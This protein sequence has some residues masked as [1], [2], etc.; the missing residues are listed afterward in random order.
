MLT[1]ALAGGYLTRVFGIIPVIAIPGAGYLT[2]GLLMTAWLH[3]RPHSARSQARRPP[4]QPDRRVPR[5]DDY[6]S[7]HI[8]D[9]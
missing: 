5:A 2:A 3:D 1:G 8:H 6:R 7:G 4:S 9:M